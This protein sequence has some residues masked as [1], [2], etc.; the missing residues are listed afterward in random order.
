MT[1]PVRPALTIRDGK[2]V[3][4][5]ELPRPGRSPRSR[6]AFG[7]GDVAGE[8][9]GRCGRALTRSIGA[10]SRP[11]SATSHPDVVFEPIRSS[12]EGAL[13]RARGNKAVLRGQSRKFRLVSPELHRYSRP[14][15]RA[16]AGDR[17]VSP[18]L[19]RG[20]GIETDAHRS[21]PS[22]LPV[23]A[24]SSTGRTTAIARRPS[25]PPGY[26]SRRLREDLS[27]F[28][29]G[30]LCSGAPA[31]GGAKSHSSPRRSPHTAG[32]QVR[33]RVGNEWSPVA[34]ATERGIAGERDRR[35]GG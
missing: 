11:G 35:G 3:R 15:R 14:R 23:T 5:R 19:P 34:A 26:R 17:N 33:Y 31:V 28:F 7:V 8:H 21:P 24:C 20:S 12:I 9:R 27:E 4:R 30:E 10:I 18:S 2:V 22:R 16:C 32:T 6:R 29:H 13:S 25:K 1:L